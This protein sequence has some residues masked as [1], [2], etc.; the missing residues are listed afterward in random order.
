MPSRPGCWGTTWAIRGSA[1]MAAWYQRGSD[2]ADRDHFGPARTSPDRPSFPAES[3]AGGQRTRRRPARTEAISKD[4]PWCAR[5]PPIVSGWRQSERVWWSPVRF[6]L[7]RRCWGWYTCH[8]HADAAPGGLRLPSR[9]GW[10]D[11]GPLEHH[12]W[13]PVG[14]KPIRGSFRYSGGGR[15]GTIGGSRL[16]SASPSTHAHH[17]ERRSPRPGWSPRALNT[18]A[19]ARLTRIAQDVVA[20]RSQGGQHG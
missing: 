5:A 11:P 9:Q 12:P 6:G 15:V 18:G 2:N 4:H 19:S 16:E 8:L 7:T 17:I 1:S 14:A 10:E 13:P 3:G 20:S